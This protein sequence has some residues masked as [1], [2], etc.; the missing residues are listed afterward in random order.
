MTRSPPADYFL[1]PLLPRAAVVFLAAPLALGGAALGLVVLAAGAGLRAAGLLAAG[2]AAGFFAAG[3]TAG[4]FAAGR[5]FGPLAAVALG[6]FVVVAVAFV[7][8]TVADTWGSHGH[9][10]RMC[11]VDPFARGSTR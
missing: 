7:W 3:L 5:P 2:F 11:T 6:L 9:G 10:D 1:R 4:F 8:L